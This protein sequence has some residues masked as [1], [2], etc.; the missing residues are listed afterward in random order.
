[1]NL[2]PQHAIIASILAY[3]FC[4]GTLVLINKLTLHFLPFPSLVV[5]FQ[6]L[7]CILI[8]YGASAFNVI[9]VDALKWDFV[10]PYMLYVL[11]FSTGVYCN[12]R[13]LNIS[14][15]ETVIVFR[16]LT[17]MVVTF[18][19]ALCLGREWPSRRSWAGLSLLIIGAYGYA[20]NDEKFQTQGYNAYFWPSLYTLIIALEMAYGKKIV[21]DV[22][23][24]TRSGP[25]IYTN[26]ISFVPMLLMANVGNEYSKFWEFF[27]GNLDGKLPVA[28]IF[29]L[30]AGSVIGTAIGYSGWWCRSLVSAT[31]FTLIGV[32]NKCLTILLNILIWDQHAN[33]QGILSL[34]VCLAGGI[35][36]EQA[37]MKTGEVKQTADAANIELKVP[38]TGDE[39]EEMAALVDTSTD[40]KQN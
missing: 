34:F 10:K 1:M 21:K 33:P 12:M 9:D 20:S 18:M 3:S 15:V 17:P 13:S 30:M 40:A 29:L 6:L 28:S 4:S 19:D 8:I 11:F 35:I 31:S 38:T 27:W 37:P 5:A 32:V 16:A 2:S 23:L 26:L 39:D 24:K 14:N 22:P 36:Y 7:A 25:V